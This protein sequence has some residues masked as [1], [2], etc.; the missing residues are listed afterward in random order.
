[1]YYKPSDYATARRFARLLGATSV[2]R[3]AIPL[4]SVD[5]TVV[6][7]RDFVKSKGHR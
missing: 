3:P 2:V 6:I 5:I 7:G 4:D 1:V